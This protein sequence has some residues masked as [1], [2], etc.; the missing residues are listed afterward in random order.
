MMPHG[1]ATVLGDSMSVR[2]TDAEIDI[3]KSE[4]APRE[5]RDRT[6]GH[7]QA[8]SASPSPVSPTLPLLFRPTASARAEE[9][10]VVAAGRVSTTA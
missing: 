8:T 7:D 10:V 9:V 1:A 3:S 5:G 4:G 2:R 6:V